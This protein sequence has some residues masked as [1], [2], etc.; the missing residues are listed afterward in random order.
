MRLCKKCDNSVALTTVRCE[1]C[2]RALPG[3]S[4]RMLRRAIVRGG[5]A[6]AAIGVMGAFA[7]A[8]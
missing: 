6:L 1:R 8:S 3:F 7:L 4:H 5:M 2:G